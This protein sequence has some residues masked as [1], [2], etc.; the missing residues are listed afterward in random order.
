VARLVKGKTLIVIAHRLSTICD[1]DK[2]YVIEHGRIHSS[3]THNEL[4]AEN[5]LYRKMWNAHISAKDTE[6]EEL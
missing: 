4:L 5:G 1:A 2:I 3:G 6:K